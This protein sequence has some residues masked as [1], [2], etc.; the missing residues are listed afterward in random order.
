MSI[1]PAEPDWH[2][3][4]AQRLHRFLRWLIPF[5]AAFML[6]EGLAFLLFQD[7]VLGVAS[8]TTAGCLMTTQ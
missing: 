4:Q 6:L 8:L 2:S 5:A 3:A 7:T 1:P